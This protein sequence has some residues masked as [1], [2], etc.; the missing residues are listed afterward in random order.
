[1]TSFVVGGLRLEQRGVD[2]AHA[3]PPLTEAVSLVR[4]L[5]HPLYEAD[6]ELFLGIATAPDPTHLDRALTLYRSVAR[7]D[8]WGIALVHY[9]PRRRRVD[10][11]QDP[12]GA[13]RMLRGA[14][15]L[16]QA[17]ESDYLIGQALWQVGF[18]A[19]AQW[20]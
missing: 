13:V 8:R 14:L 4:R 5:G 19:L 18:V 1:M 9:S 6:A 10:D 2:R 17:L 15:R 12:A 7:T 11:R 3:V 20:R 16:A